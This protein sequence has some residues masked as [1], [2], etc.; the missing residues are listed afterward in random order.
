MADRFVNDKTLAATE[1]YMAIAAEAGIAPVT[2]AVAWSMR[3]DFVASTIIGARN[4]EQLGDSLAA[5]ESP[6]SAEI[7]HACDAVQREILYPMG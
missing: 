3:H 5:L 7:L 4:R 2:L 6:L 1:R